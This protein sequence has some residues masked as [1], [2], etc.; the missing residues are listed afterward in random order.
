MRSRDIDKKLWKRIRRDDK[1][2]KMY[3]TGKY[4]IKEL[5]PKFSIKKSQIHR[6]IEFGR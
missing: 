4:T 2:R 1:I 5:E 3:A 6:I